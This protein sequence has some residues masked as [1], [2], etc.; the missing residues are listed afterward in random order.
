MTQTSNPKQIHT[1]SFSDDEL[2]PIVSSDLSKLGFL[3]SILHS[4]LLAIWKLSQNNI[5]SIPC[6]KLLTLTLKGG[7]NMQSLTAISPKSIKLILT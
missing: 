1:L 4:S 3:K 5:V 2:L 7:A 6:H